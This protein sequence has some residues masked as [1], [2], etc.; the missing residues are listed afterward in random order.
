MQEERDCPKCG[1]KMQKGKS[2]T[3]SETRIAEANI[4]GE[5][6]IYQRGVDV[7]NVFFCSFCK[8]QENCP[9]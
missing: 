5:E 9:E 3:E 1:R 2:I 8:H 6:D 4:E 7:K